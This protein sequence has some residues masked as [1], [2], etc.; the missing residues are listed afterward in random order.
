MEVNSDAQLDTSANCEK[1]PEEQVD[2]YCDCGEPI[3]RACAVIDHRLH[4]NQPLSKVFA[5]EKKMIATLLEKAKP[6]MSALKAEISSREGI[7]EALQ[8][9]CSDINEQIENFVNARIAQWESKRES[10]KKDLREMSASKV[11]SLK[12]RR[13]ALLLLVSRVENV[14]DII[15]KC[16]RSCEK[17]VEFLRKKSQFDEQLK[18]LSATSQHIQPCNKVTIQLEETHPLKIYPN[19][20]DV[21]NQAKIRLLEFDKQGNRVG[22]SANSDF[23]DLFNNWIMLSCFLFLMG[24]IFFF[25]CLDLGK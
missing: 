5:R 17:K 16:G 11:D 1:H 24:L 12:R 2:L 18:E 14:K 25:K 6:Q 9:N 10:L 8:Q 21:S 13:E 20:H 4:S 22:P 3:C 15:K 23:I 19:G 7:E